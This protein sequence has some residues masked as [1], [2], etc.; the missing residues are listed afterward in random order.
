VTQTENRWFPPSPHRER[1]EEAIAQGVAH[2]VERGH[3]VAPLLVFEDGGAIDLPRVRYQMTRRGM[4]LAAGDG[5]AA[6]G[7]THFGDVCGSVDEIKGRVAEAARLEE[8]DAAYIQAL[9]EDIGYMLGRMSRRSEQYRAFLGDVRAIVDEMLATPPPDSVSAEAR[10]AAFAE[11]LAGDG[12]LSDQGR[13][14]IYAAAEHVRDLANDL[15]G[16]LGAGKEA[17]MR[18]GKLYA[19]IQGGRVWQE[20]PGGGEAR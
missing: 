13:E 4:A 8:L 7:A 19:D 17:A 6:K 14:T 18:I 20:Q 11:S 3:N 5:P 15:E 1:V 12:D 16:Y 10:T 2:I 9:I